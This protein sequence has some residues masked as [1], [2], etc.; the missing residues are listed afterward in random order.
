MS[1]P[2]LSSPFEKA[3]PVWATGRS[4]TMNDMV[5]FRTK[6]DKKISRCVTL[7]LTGST[8]YRIRM[9]GIF[10]AT[11]PARGPKGIF[12]V[13]EIELP[14][15]NETNTLEIEVLGSNVNSYYYMDQPSFLQA[16][17]L[18]ENQVVAWTGQ[19]FRIY[20]LS[21]ERIQ[22]TPRYSFQRMFCEAYRVTPERRNLHELPLTITASVR[23]LPRRVPQPEYRIDRSYAPI[24]HIRRRYK[25]EAEV[26]AINY[27]DGVG[28]LGFKGFP[29]NNIELNSYA[30]VCRCV[31]DEQGTMTSTLFCGAIN[32]TGFIRLKISCTK[33]GR[34]AVFFSEIGDLN[35]GVNA[36]RLHTT[37]AIFWD[38]Q[39]AGTYNLE[40]LEPYTLKYAE[41][42]MLYGEA[43]VAEFSLREFKSPL[44]W[45]RHFDLASPD[46]KKIF[47]AGCQTF[48]AN[49]VD[50]F[51]DCPSRERGGWLCDS[52][53][54]GRAS[55]LL[56][57]GTMLERFFLENFAYA[58]K[59]DGLPE[60]AFPMVYP[61]DNPDGVFIPNWGM[62]LILEIE[63]YLQR[64]GDRQLIDDFKEKVLAFIHYI[65]TFCNSDGLLEDLPGVVFIE[66]SQA[67]KYSQNV[68][69]PS[70]MTYTAALESVSRLYNMPELAIR[71]KKMRMIIQQQSW[72]S[73]WF[74]DHGIRQP[75]G[76]LKVPPGDITETCQ[77]Y[78][79]MFKCAT[80]QTHPELWKR[81][82][83]DFGP[84]RLQKDA[85]PQIWPSNAFIGNIMRLDILSQYGRLR[86]LLD[87]ACGY[88]KK[89]A[90]ATGTLW[91]F[92]S[93]EASCCHGFA[94]YINVL[95][96]RAG[97][98]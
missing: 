90:D 76:T 29:K 44:A 13:D 5:L 67:N 97:N 66:W 2:F 43:T 27:I 1:A 64:S 36:L 57:G 68:N 24:S 46:L 19:H 26:P 20:D 95:L 25:P 79:F 55:H 85:W 52:F 94:S 8:L 41:V 62:W 92:D 12:R 39:E 60:G 56:T 30:E 49:A 14:V 28:Q 11:G 89:M 75:D 59:F 35:N 63:E 32:N 88:Y 18:A 23:Y 9:D 96:T 16:E 93:T 22:K 48:A 31:L 40:S 72:D 45:E 70:N 87:E 98:A 51:T 82:I 10:L 37:D 73:N 80:P 54:M 15:T 17:V 77:Y 6:L 47:E 78:A 86:Q 81:L 58:P 84:K 74:R 91:E 21:G 69:Y 34:L 61:S 53:F 71:A 3:L 33:P 65:D 38:L 7:R 42:L 4:H 83:T 50:C